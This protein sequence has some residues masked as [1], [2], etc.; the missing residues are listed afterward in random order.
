[1]QTAVLKPW[2]SSEE[3]LTFERTADV[4]HEYVNGEVYAMVGTSRRHNVITQ[5]LS[6][7]LRP[8]I[9]RHGCES[10]TENVKVRVD[11][12]NAFYYPDL[13]VTCDPKDDDPYIV[14][15]PSLI[16]EVLSES[17]EAIDRRE[18]RAHYQMIPSLREFALIAQDGRCVDIYRRNGVEWT[19]ETVTEGE[20]SFESVGVTVALDDLYA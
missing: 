7:A 5:N 11:L 19:H 10:Y 3:Y 2:I 13:V 4:R 9:R 20:V 14:H 8:S 15:A 6:A 12:A 18:K 17:T 1:M 16:V